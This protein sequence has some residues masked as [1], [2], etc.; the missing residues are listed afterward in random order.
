MS[1]MSKHNL[2]Y[3]PE[4][5]QAFQRNSD[6]GYEPEGSYGF[7]RCL[8]HGAPNPLIRWHHHIEYELHLITETSGRMFVGDYIGEFKPGNLVLTGPN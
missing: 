6:I 2:K 3:T 8:E 5:E 7:L 4:L 1:A